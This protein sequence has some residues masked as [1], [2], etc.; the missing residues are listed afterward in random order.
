LPKLEDQF[1]PIDQESI[2]LSPQTVEILAKM[3]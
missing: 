1:V 2:F 3:T